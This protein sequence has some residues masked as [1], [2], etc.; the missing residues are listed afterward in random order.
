MQANWGAWA[1]YFDAG[2]ASP[3]VSAF[4]RPKPV[5]ELYDSHADPWQVHNLAE[6]PAHAERVRAMDAALRTR[7]LE[8]RDLGPIPEAMLHE[9]AGDGKA[10]PTPYALAMDTAA[11]PL[12]AVLD[13]ARVASAGDFADGWREL[14]AFCR[15]AEPA[16]R[17]WGAYGFFLRRPPIHGTEAEGLLMDMMAR[18][19]SAANRMMAAQALGIC[20]FTETAHAALVRELDRASNGYAMLLGFNALQYS[21]ADRLLRRQDWERWKAAPIDDAGWS[22]AQRIIDDALDLWPQRR[23]VD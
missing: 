3:A 1:D 23:R 10:H 5:V 4:F 18:D 8:T 15:S 11:Y 21:H 7:M 22:Y 20:G 13:A 14:V 12:G 17:F 2:K 16:V 6:D 19:A 9:R